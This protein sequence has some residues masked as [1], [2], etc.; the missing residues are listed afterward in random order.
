MIE[1]TTVL[2]IGDVPTVVDSVAHLLRAQTHPVVP[3][4]VGSARWTRQFSTHVRVFIRVI[5]T[6]ILSIAHPD[7]K[8]TQCVGTDELIR[9]ARVGC[10]KR[11][12]LVGN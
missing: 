12:N 8:L 2:F 4:A 5:S 1:L 11:N 9:T 7:V 10:C 6:V 3:T